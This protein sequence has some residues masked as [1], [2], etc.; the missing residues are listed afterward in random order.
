ME[1]ILINP[2]G[3]MSWQDKYRESQP[4]Q[5]MYPYSLVYLQNYMIKKGIKTKLF[6]LYWTD[7]TQLIKYCDGLGSPIVGVTSQ[8]YNR[9]K[10]VDIIRRVKKKN[11][12]SIMVVGGKH[13][14]YCSEEALEHIKEIDIVVRGEGENTLYEL[15]NAL[16]GGQ[17]LS[18]VDGITYRDRGKILIN[19][20]RTQETNIDRFS[21]D[22]EK[23][24]Q[25]E[26]SEGVLF[27][28]YE[29]EGIRSLPVLLG[30]GCSQKCAFCS[31]KKIKYRVRTLKNVREE[32]DYLRKKHN[33]RYFSFSDPSFCE[34]KA[35]VKEFCQWLIRDNID[36]KW[37]CE[38][39]VDTPVELLELMAKAGCISLDFGLESG[40]EKVLKAIQK[41]VDVTQTLSFAREC[42]RLGIRTL[43][44]VMVSLPEETEADAYQT[45]E[46]ARKLSKYVRYISISVTKILPGTE[47]ETMAREKGILPPDFSWF[48]SRFYHKYTD[49]GPENVPLYIENLSIEFIRSFLKKISSIK[50]AEYTTYRDLITI[51][52]KGIRR[53]PNQSLYSTFSDTSHFIRGLWSRLSRSR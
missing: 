24:P 18:S 20:D 44:F 15:V 52:R 34:R 30:R 45:L 11:S 41:N 42:H 40:S 29:N 19:K 26:F 27:R 7:P 13:F 47:L 12:T 3:G 50:F 51:V 21:L 8:T 31:Y 23:L 1:L 10:A 4:K 32:I 16:R 43:V 9:D 6:D 33:K 2:V 37:Y 36:I 39:R 14:S 5:Y 22:Y 46:M 53:I 25:N 49:L 17:D 28:N 35:F 48:D 38:A